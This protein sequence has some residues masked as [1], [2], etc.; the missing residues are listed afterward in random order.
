MKLEV[1]LVSSRLVSPRMARP[2]STLCS[3]TPW[4]CVSPLLPSTRWTPPS[5][6]RPV[7]RKSSRRLPTSS[8]RSASTPRLLPSS[9]SLV[10]TATTC[11]LLPP[12]APGT[13]AGRRRARVAPRSPARPCLRHRLRRA[14]QASQRQAPPSSS[15]GCLQDRWYW[16]SARWPYRDRYPQARHGRHLRPRQG[17]CLL[18]R[19]GHCPEPPWSGRCRLRSRPRLPHRPH[20]LQVLR[21][22]REDRPP[23]R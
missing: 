21:D 17:R 22:P 14:P 15:P 3:P 23:Y 7:T 8:R 4:V 9:P 11:C 12:T 18:Q 16:H 20:C 1:S 19:P 2:V 10:S 13:R 5:G 6:L